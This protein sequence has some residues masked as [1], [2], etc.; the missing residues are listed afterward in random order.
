MLFTSLYSSAFLLSSSFSSFLFLSFLF[1]FLR[2]ILLC[3]TFPLPTLHPSLLFRSLLFFFPSQSTIHFYLHLCCINVFCI[4]TTFYPKKKNTAQPRVSTPVPL[5]VRK[6]NFPLTFPTAQRECRF[7]LD[8]YCQTYSLFTLGLSFT[9]PD[10]NKIKLCLIY[11]AWLA[12]S[13]L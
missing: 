4:L 11:G 8:I 5:F 1:L 2:F 7:V 9:V 3:P 6:H 12:Q 13:I 10:R